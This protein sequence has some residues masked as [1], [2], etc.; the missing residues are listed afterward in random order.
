MLGNRCPECNGELL[1]EVNTKH[2]ICNKCGLYATR[3]Q[4]DDLKDRLRPQKKRSKESEYFEWW[5]SKGKK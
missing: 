5:M 2:F 4:L 3:E 1:Y